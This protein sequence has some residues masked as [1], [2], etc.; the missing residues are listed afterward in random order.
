MEV[1]N[2]VD[3]DV[4]VDVLGGVGGCM[5]G[6]PTSHVSRPAHQVLLR[7]IADLGGRRHKDE[8]DF[9]GF[10]DGVRES[11][12]ERGTDVSPPAYDASRRRA[13]MCFWGTV[14]REFGK[15][16]VQWVNDGWPRCGLTEA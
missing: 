15:D 2:I 10:N 6:S 14:L 4:D 16:W 13:M 5:C 1:C 7:C 12:S 8:E 3:V 11:E 9:L